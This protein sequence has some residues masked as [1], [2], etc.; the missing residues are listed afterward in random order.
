MAAQITSITG[1]Q[2]LINLQEFRADWN[3]LTAI[4]FSGLTNLT[5]IDI[6]DNDIPGEGTPS[7]TSVNLT[8]CTAL[9]Q[10]RLDDSNFSAGIPNLTG[11]T[12]LNYFRIDDC[13]ISGDIDL[14]MLSALTGF[15]LSDNNG[16]TSV[17]LPE[18]LLLDIR[19]DNTG[20]TETAV[21]NI[22]QWVDGSGV[23]N[24]YMNLSGG[25]SALP[26]GYGITAITSLLEKVWIVLTNLPISYSF[27]VR[28]NNTLFCGS[29]TGDSL[30]YSDSPVLEE[31]VNVY[32]D[33][34]LTIPTFGYVCDCTNNL[35]YFM[36]FPGGTLPVG[37]PLEPCV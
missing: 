16:I 3:S 7:L 28:K 4:D 9:E 2:N 19:L 23:T 26:T 1:L 33:I 35:S 11:L 13:N 21:N 14:S 15:D 25:T 20:L 10:L 22:L 6:S 18:A 8:G 24:G 27:S 32:N 17:T 29:L 31:G 36:P 37:S 5:Y 30:I 34:A 12:S